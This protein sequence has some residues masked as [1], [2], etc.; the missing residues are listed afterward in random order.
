MALKIEWSI[1]PFLGAFVYFALYA[2]NFPTWAMILGAALGS[3]DL[4]IR[5]R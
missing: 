1:R 5:R 3:I 4:K 2:L